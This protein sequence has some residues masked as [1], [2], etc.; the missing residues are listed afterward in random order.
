MFLNAYLLY[1]RFSVMSKK[2][3]LYQFCLTTINYTYSLQGIAH[4]L[5]MS[6]TSP[7]YSIHWAQRK[8]ETSLI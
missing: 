5:K 1:W 3:D 2:L 8:E 7:K 6:E 4:G